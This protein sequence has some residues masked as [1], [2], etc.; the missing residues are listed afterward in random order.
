M[1]DEKQFEKMLKE[2]AKDK[3][4]DT[5]AEMMTTDGSIKVSST[6]ETW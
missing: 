1:A 2:R 6:L 5:L 3:T 4:N